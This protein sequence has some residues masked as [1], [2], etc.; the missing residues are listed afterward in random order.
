MPKQRVKLLKMLAFSPLQLRAREAQ[1]C[2]H[3][4]GEL[5]VDL[6]L[7]VWGRLLNGAQQRRR[8]LSSKIAKRNREIKWLPSPDQFLV[9]KS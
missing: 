4:H 7:H 5:V 8:R 1:L 2:V 3:H 6:W 9:Y